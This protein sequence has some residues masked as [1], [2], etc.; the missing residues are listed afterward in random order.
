MNGCFHE[1]TTPGF[2][3]ELLL[4]SQ[5]VFGLSSRPRNRLIRKFLQRFAKPSVREPKR[6]WAFRAAERMRAKYEELWRWDPRD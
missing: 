1:Q 5:Q 4:S 2:V 3:N 6:S